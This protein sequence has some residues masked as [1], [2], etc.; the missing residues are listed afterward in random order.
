MIADS[1]KTSPYNRDK[2]WFLTRNCGLT[3]AEIAQQSALW[4]IL[5]DDLAGQEKDIR[6]FAARAG[7]FGKRRIIL[8][9]AGSSAF[10]GEAAVAG[11]EAGVMA[12]PVPTTDIVS[13]PGSF[14]Y[15]DTPSLLVSFARSGNSPESR[16]AV[17][18]ARKIVKDLFEFAIVCDPGSTLA[19]LSKGSEK[20]GVLV[21]PPGSCDRGFAMTS[22]I[23]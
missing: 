15:P 23:T 7:G 21:M 17:E 10:A 22:S 11:K 13:S 5:A 18:Y 20:R 12:V 1:S 8:T 4:R 19:E 6:D 14:L 3:A 9:G 16:G 2:L